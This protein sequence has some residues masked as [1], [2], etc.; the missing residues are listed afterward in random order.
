MKTSHLWRLTSIVVLLAMT[1]S[2]IG[3]SFAAPLNTQPAA[4][5]TGM[6][7]INPSF[8]GVSQPLSSLAP[9]RVDP[10]APSAARKLQDRLVIPKTQN[11]Y[12]DGGWDAAIVQDGPVGKSMP[13]PDANFEGVNNVSG[14]LPPDTQG[15]VGTDPATGKKYYVQW[16]N[17]AF[18]IWDVTNPRRPGLTLRPR[19]RQY[20]LDRNGHDVRCEQRRRPHHPV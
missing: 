13:A 7:V 16:V 17:L 3:S 19:G 5:Q 1:I 6:R 10:N 8:V 9:I 12:K 14:V 20:S 15:D 11:S 18:E 4:P 2:P